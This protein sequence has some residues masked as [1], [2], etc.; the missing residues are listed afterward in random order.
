MAVNGLF[1]Q[2][3]FWIMLPLSAVQGLWLRR[4]AIRLPEASG[5]RTG[6]SGQGATLHLLALGD[7]IIAGVGTG[8]M[9]RSLPVQFA[10]A[11]SENLQYSVHWHVDGANGADIADLR[12]S[13]AQLPQRLHADV[14]LISVG[15]NNVTGLSST[16][17]WRSQLELMVAD[18]R[19]RWPQARVIFAG[20]PP[21]GQFPL[22]PQPLRFTLG[23]RAATLDSIAAGV[24]SQHA[25]MLHIPT[26][27][28]PLQQEFCADGFHP[29]AESCTY[30][31][32]VL[33]HRFETANLVPP[34]SGKG[35]A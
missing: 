10:Q 3:G 4:T 33:A 8:S 15:V 26:D 6:V 27:I 18:I 2:L 13:I 29:S 20:L 19:R 12:H 7:S 35:S 14:I 5:A 22:P 11:L 24:I 30:W 1:R 17:Q 28:N 32:K 9:D 34:D 25:G 21:M 23:Q 31:A 16:R